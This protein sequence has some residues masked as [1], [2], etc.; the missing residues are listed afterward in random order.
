MSRH[1]RRSL[2]GRGRRSGGRRQ[3]GRAR[4]EVE[5]RWRDI[6]VVELDIYV[7]E[8]AALVVSQHRLRGADAIHLASAAVLGSGVTMVS[9]DTRL[10]QAALAAG[11]DVAP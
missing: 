8:V 5:E 10:R 6:A 11:L 1:T 7:S 4:L 2:R 3:L 9:R